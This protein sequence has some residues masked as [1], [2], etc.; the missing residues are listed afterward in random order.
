MPWLAALAIPAIWS[1]GR[2]LFSST[3]GSTALGAT[4]GY[5][6]GQ[7]TSSAQPAPAYG[8]PTAA[9]LLGLAAVMLAGVA[10]WKQVKRGM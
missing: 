2:S 7:S 8:L 1:F 9:Q 5:F 3:V 4:G 10:L 6:F